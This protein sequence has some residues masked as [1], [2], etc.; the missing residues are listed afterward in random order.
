MVAILSQA[1]NHS[2]VHIL[3]LDSDV[4]DSLS[5]GEC[6][7]VIPVL[8]SNNLARPLVLYTS[9]R[10]QWRRLDSKSDLSS[11]LIQYEFQLIDGLQ[12]H[13]VLIHDG[14]VYQDVIIAQEEEEGSNNSHTTQDILV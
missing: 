13:G 6:C 1:I 5:R 9:V 11:F 12:E 4:T 14:E 8:L 10:Y 2:A 7:E 3:Q